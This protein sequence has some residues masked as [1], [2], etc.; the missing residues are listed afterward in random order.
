MPLPFVAV[1]VLRVL[2]K[3]AAAGAVAAPALV[4]ALARAADP[5]PA[6]FAA[7]H[8]MNAGGKPVGLVLAD[9]DGDGAP[10]VVSA[11][12]AAAA[13]VDVIIRRN[14]GTGATFFASSF[15]VS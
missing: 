5:V 14:D 12:S 15:Q 13:P 1:R 6:T 10:D 11:D 8:K 2:R 3:L 9:L 4:P 7:P